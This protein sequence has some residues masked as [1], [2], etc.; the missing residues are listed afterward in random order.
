[1]TAKIIENEKFD[2]IYLTGAGV[3]ASLLGKPDLGLVTMTEMLSQAE[4][5]ADVCNIPIIADM[6]TG[7]GGIF[8]ITRMI[9]K[10]EKSGLA[11][12][13][14]EDQKWP[15]RCG[16]LKKVELISIEEMKERILAAVNARYNQNF[17]VIAR[18]DAHGT[19]NINEVIERGSAYMEFGADM[20]FVNGLTT[21]KQVEII[22]KS[23]P[24]PQIYNYSTSGKAPKLSLNE[25]ENLGFRIAIF[26]AF[27]LLAS[28]FATISLLKELKKS[29]TLKNYE[30]KMISFED[31]NDIL[32]LKEYE[33]YEWKLVK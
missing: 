30:N 13:H 20:L 27:C 21:K 1:M 16:Y 26:P 5:I 14:I 22:S 10:A 6:D 7:F 33:E 18:I 28:C 29:G 32:K 23:L 2:L 15:K 9:Q 8:N 31:W 11:G 17:Q 4:Y 25:I 12:I 24:F 19:K 3:T